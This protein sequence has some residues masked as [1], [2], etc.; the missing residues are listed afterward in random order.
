MDKTLQWAI[1]RIMDTIHPQFFGS[2]TLQF[3]A[4]KLQCIRTEHT[5]KP[6][7]GALT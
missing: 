7:T 2:I 3:Q 5:E 4:G 1:S 6:E